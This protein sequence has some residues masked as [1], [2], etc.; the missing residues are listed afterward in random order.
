[1][2]NLYWGRSDRTLT[3]YIP[4]DCD[5]NCPFCTSKKQVY[6]NPNILSYSNIYKICVGLKYVIKKI[7]IDNIVITGGEPFSNINQL[8]WILNTIALYKKE[9]NLKVYINTSLPQNTV[10]DAIDI[11]KINNIVDGISISRHIKYHLANQA[12]DD[13][14][15]ELSKYVSVRI[16]SL[17]DHTI[18]SDQIVDFINRWKSIGVQINFR[19]DYNETNSDNLRN[20]LFDNYIGINPSFSSGCN[21]C[22]TFST[23][24]KNVTIHKGLP[25][26]S[27]VYNIFGTS[28]IEINDLVMD[29]TGSLYY[30]WS[31]DSK[32]QI[33]WEMEDNILIAELKEFIKLKQDIVQKLKCAK[34]DDAPV[35]DGSHND[36]TKFSNIMD[37][38]DYERF[39]CHS[40]DIKC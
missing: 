39:S 13:D 9:Y 35:N 24:D 11:A 36:G 25:N 29:P 10:A 12:K 40:I 2:K 32:V 14:I 31:L 3:I 15:G 23:S 33:N 28:I 5:N 30:D 34:N 17:V 16:N 38:D 1:M 22:S 26:T 19:E 8:L 21:V 18:S 27:I 7:G 6:G 20:T 4:Q 37:D